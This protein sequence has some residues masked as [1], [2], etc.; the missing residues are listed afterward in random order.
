MNIYLS[1]VWVILVFLSGNRVAQAKVEANI[2]F[3]G[4]KSTGFAYKDISNRCSSPKMIQIDK[5]ESLIIVGRE[6]CG[7]AN[8]YF[9]KIAWRGEIYFIDETSVQIDSGYVNKLVGLVNMLPEQARILEEKGI[10][11]SI[12][13]YERQ[14]NSISHFFE[15]TKKSGIA[16]LNSEIYDHGDYSNGTGFNIEF[17][18]PTKKTIKYVTV[19]FEGFNAVGDSVKSRNGKIVV[20][21]GIG[22]IEPDSFAT[23][24]KAYAWS[25]NI[26][27][28]VEIVSVT[29]EFMDGTKKVV[30]NPEIITMSKYDYDFLHTV[31]TKG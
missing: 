14:L 27:Q 15:K 8:I 2:V 20:L 6:K 28:R 13:E 19:Q 30:K 21:R 9:Y 3:G 18:N 24:K 11:L 7:F 25:T 5:V 16:I 23:Y 29:I 1:L 10:D 17:Y 22:P 12:N 31:Q 4:V 26:V